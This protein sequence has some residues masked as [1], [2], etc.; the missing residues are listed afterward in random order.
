MVSRRNYL[1]ITVVMFIVFFLFQFTNV[2]LEGWDGYEKNSYVRT[3]EELAGQ[4]SAYEAGKKETQTDSSSLRKRLVYIGDGEDILGTV[5]RN[6]VNYT[7]KGIDIYSSVQEYEK[8]DYENS[9]ELMVIDSEYVD[10]EREKVCEQLRAY[11]DQGINLI[12]CNLPEVSVIKDNRELRD[13]LGIKDVR[14]EKT[15]VEGIHLYD[16]FLFGGEAYYLTEDE[17]ELKEKQD[18]ELEFPWYTLSEETKVY[19][20][21][22]PEEEMDSEDYP[23][24]IWQKKFNKARVF[25]V[26]GSY[27]EEAEGLG[28]LSAMSAEMNAYD[29]YPVVNAQNMVILNYPSMASEN[30][31]GMEKWYGQSMSEVFRNIAWP[32]VVSV[33]RRNTLGLTCM[34]TPQYDYEEDNFPSKTE[35][36]FYMKRLKEQSAEAGLSGESVSDTPIGQKLDED[37]RF[38]KEALPEYKFTSFYAGK[39]TESELDSAL[40]DSMLKSIRTVISDYAGDSEVIGYQSE[41]VTRQNILSDGVRHTYREDFRMRSI[42]TALGYTSV[43]MDMSRA[44]YPESGQD[45]VDKIVSEFSSNVGAYWQN[46]N[47]FDGTTLSECD[48]RIRNFLSLDYE[49]KREGDAIQLD[50]KDAV[51]PVWFILRTEGET[52]SRVKGGNFSMLEEGV[53]LI[54]AEDTH[55]TIEL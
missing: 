39:L 30:E 6:W 3:K 16:G 25:A 46:F 17:E 31:E 33:Y 27:M 1:A 23:A 41:Y 5:V 10:W 12:F 42:E 29:L 21:G 14:A 55:V 8:S 43:G 53:Y 4:G 45:E 26:N 32:S 22:M 50:I 24:V 51:T 13:L 18:M 34:I 48:Q 35:L 44:A 2:V 15:N 36:E 11:V 54:E 52:V 40:H 19:M 38:M 20:Q 37:E 47:T 7:K 28:L 49:E 9:P